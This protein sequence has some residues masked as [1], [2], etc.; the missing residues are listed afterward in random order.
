MLP[1]RAAIVRKTRSNP[2]LKLSY[3][4][5]FNGAH[6]RLNEGGIQQSLF[7]AEQQQCTI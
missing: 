7:T 6:G 4:S 5:A 1:R 2:V 3:Q